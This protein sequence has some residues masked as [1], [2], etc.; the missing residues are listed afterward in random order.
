MKR[1]FTPLQMAFVGLIAICATSCQREKLSEVVKD[2]SFTPVNA[3]LPTRVDVTKGSTYTLTGADLTVPATINFSSVT[4]SAFTI[5]LSTN[6]DTVASLV[7][8]GVLAPGTVAFTTG[9]AA[10]APQITIPAGVTSFTFDVIISRS[11]IELGFGKTLAAVI[12]ATAATK[13][14]KV[15][16]D[17]GSMIVTVKTDDVITAES[18][19]DISFGVPNKIVDLSANPSYYSLGSLYI[20]VNIPVKLNGDAGSE[21]TVNVASAPDS[22]TAGIANGLL[23]GSE[24]FPD[25][26]LSITNPGV[27]IQT[28][29]TSAFLTVNLKLNDLLAIQPAPAVPSNTKPTMAFTLKSASKYQITTTRVSTVYVVMDPNFFR[30]YYGKPFL[31]KGAVGAASDPI[32]CA[33][34]DFGG[35]GIAFH[36]DTHKDGDGGWR[37]SDYVDVSGDYSPRSVVGWTGSGEWLTYSIYVEETGNYSM[38]TMIGGGGDG[39]TYSVFIDGVR[40]NQTP[41]PVTRTDYRLQIDNI[42]NIQ[43]TKGYHILKMY[44]DVARY[45]VRG[46][47]FTRLA[48]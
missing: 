30:P 20:T 4:T 33:Y 10:V 17:K 9:S 47:F 14:N 2:Q 23:A 25:A 5:N 1:I 45:D 21:F 28:G 41:Y 46:M 35:E 29:T 13:G 36:D 15:V 11:A 43:L 18:I 39:G 26:K 6:T 27:I 44:W 8:S 48:N 7:S 22:V 3:T 34:Y 31:I 37:T 24:L 12:K 19:H 32:Y 42:H 38:N 16:G 40:Y